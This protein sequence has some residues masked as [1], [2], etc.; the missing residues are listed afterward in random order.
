MLLLC[1]PHRAHFLL[2]PA[3]VLLQPGEGARAAG[4]VFLVCF[5]AG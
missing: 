4:G 3:H 2:H 5:W 1:N